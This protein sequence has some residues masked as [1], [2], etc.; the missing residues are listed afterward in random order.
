MLE[1]I[2]RDIASQITWGIDIVLSH[3]YYPLKSQ[4]WG[5]VMIN[6]VIDRAIKMV[7]SQKKFAMKVGVSQPNVWYWLHSK[8]KVSPERVLSIVEATGGMV[9]AYEIRPDLPDLFPHPNQ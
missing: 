6:D 5:I 4:P 3:G 2:A 9:K 1:H 7:G 8:K